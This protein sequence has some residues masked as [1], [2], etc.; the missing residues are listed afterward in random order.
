LRKSDKLFLPGITEQSRQELYRGW[1]D[2]V[3]RVKVL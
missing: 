2:A 3:G 1:L